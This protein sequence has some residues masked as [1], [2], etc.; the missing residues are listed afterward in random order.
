MLTMEQLQTV[1]E[2]KV[3]LK[4]IQRW[5]AGA[6]HGSTTTGAAYVAEQALSAALISAAHL[7]EKDPVAS[8]VIAQKGWSV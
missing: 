2:L 4:A 5:R 3:A 1:D 8:A 6:T 7:G